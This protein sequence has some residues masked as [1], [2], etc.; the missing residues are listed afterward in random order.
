VETLTARLPIDNLP[1]L[2][3]NSS[4]F[5]A[6][7]GLDRRCTA[8]QIRAAYRLLARQHH[9]DVNGGCPQSA[10]RTLQLNAAYE[11]LS[12]PERRRAYDETLSQTKSRK[13]AG[14]GLKADRNVSKEVQ[15]RI[16]EFLRG[17]TL[18]VRVNDPGNPD[19]PETYELI[20]PPMTAP[21]TRFRV[22]R[23]GGGL[24]FIRARARADFRFKV[25]GSDVR[26]DLRISPERAAQVGSEMIKGLTGQ[27]RVNIPRGAKSGEIVR[28]PGEGLPK[29]RGGRGDLLV[30]ITYRP[31]VRI[32][33]ASRG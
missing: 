8:E 1:V 10:A 16:E 17:T 11:V 24:V 23:T 13:S 15:L 25:R 32:A 26:C 5:Y 3:F 12:D 7:L 33:R 9:P 21:G 30:R 27:L 29:A 18:Q 14:H 4:D 28:L 6:T 22:P 19:G 31:E 2:P 20:V